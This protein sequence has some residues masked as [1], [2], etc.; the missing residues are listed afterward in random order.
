MGGFFSYCLLVFAYVGIDL[1]MLWVEQ[2][3][4]SYEEGVITEP[5]FMNKHNDVVMRL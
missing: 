1:E 4:P 3:M 5:L 2:D